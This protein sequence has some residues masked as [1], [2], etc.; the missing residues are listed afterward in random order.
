MRPIADCLNPKLITLCQGVI[1][2]DAINQLIHQ[3]L[4]EALRGTCYAGS[5]SQGCLILVVK[6]AVWASQ[7]R[8]SLPE[9]RDTL[10][11]DG[12]LY[13]LTSIKISLNALTPDNLI[14]PTKNQPVLSQIARKNLLEAGE[15]CRY[16]PLKAA[17]H[18]LADRNKG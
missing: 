10:R 2:L 11:R 5:F 7:L 13:Q 1:Q 15:L 8:Y 16:A 17:L 9:L 18:R 14:K 6:D 3:C 12:G 4:P